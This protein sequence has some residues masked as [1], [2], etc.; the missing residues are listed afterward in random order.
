MSTDMSA[1]L[2]SLFQERGFNPLTSQWESILEAHLRRAQ[3][4]RYATPQ[5]ETALIQALTRCG[6]T[7]SAK[8]PISTHYYRDGLGGPGGFSYHISSIETWQ[9]DC[10][11][12]K[13]YWTYCGD[14]EQYILHEVGSCTYQAWDAVSIYQHQIN[15]LKQM[16]P[17][18]G[19][20]DAV[21][22]LDPGGLNDRCPRLKINLRLSSFDEREKQG[23]TLDEI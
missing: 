14:D 23:E 18:I 6:Y 3:L 11:R 21:A 8:E 1:F 15:F 20:L 12:F 5:H 17:V 7:F 10:E 13:P 4:R 22:I 19:R 16:I 9:L 2:K